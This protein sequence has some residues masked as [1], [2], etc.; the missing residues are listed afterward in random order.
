MNLGKTPPANRPSATTSAALTAWL[1]RAA[2][3]DSCTLK[4]VFR[5]DDNGDYS[6]TL[7]IEAIPYTPPEEN[8]SL[9]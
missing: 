5:A 2:P 1:A 8:H 4:I 9:E 7:V 3:G 6:D